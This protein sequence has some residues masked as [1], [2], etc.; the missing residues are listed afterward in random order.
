M[1]IVLL[2][3]FLLCTACS[4]STS[5]S[6][7][8]VSFEGGGF[9]LQAPE[10]W[11]LQKV[12]GMDYPILASDPVDGFR[13]N[14]FI[15]GVEEGTLEYVEAQLLARYRN[16]SARYE[17]VSRAAWT[18][19]AGNKGLRLT[20]YRNSSDGLPL[21]SWHY[22]IQEGDRVIAV[23][24]TCARETSTVLAPVFE[25]AVYSILPEPL[26]DL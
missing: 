14:L 9:S 5:L 10:E 4:R 13:P 1:R 22:L 16:E 21:V 25:S 15:D 23:T 12:P 7:G 24:A 26:S 18:T 2:L 20:S 6:G 3:I 8:R 17:E 11:E 19:A